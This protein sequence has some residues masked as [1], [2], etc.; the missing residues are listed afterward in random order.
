MHHLNKMNWFL[1]TQP[2]YCTIN[3]PHPCCT[4]VRQ[5][6]KRCQFGNSG[7]LHSSNIKA[8]F[9]AKKVILQSLLCSSSAATCH[10]QW[11]F[12]SMTSIYRTQ[13]ALSQLPEVS[14]QRAPEPGRTKSLSCHLRLHAVPMITHIT[15]SMNKTHQSGTDAECMYIKTAS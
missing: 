14:Q 10:S 13:E 1:S 2:V 3:H 11:A 15:A 8:L 7:L 4:A 12:L 5:R 9:R 6:L